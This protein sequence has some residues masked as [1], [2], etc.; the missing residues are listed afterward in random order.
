MRTE[1]MRELDAREA[2]SACS[3]SHQDGFPGP[4]ARAPAQRVPSCKIGVQNGRAGNEIHAVRELSGLRGFRGH[5]LSKAA[6]P[7]AA[8]DSV[9]GAKSRYVRANRYDHPRSVRPRYV[10]ERRPHLITAAA[11][12]VVHIADRGG[13]NV[14]QNFVCGRLRLNGLAKA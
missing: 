10:R 1:H 6:V 4:Q 14:D 2:N 13:V 5:A 11:H 8:C 3:A 7:A 12:Q 9:T